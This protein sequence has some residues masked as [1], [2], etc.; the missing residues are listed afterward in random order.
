VGL[1]AQSWPDLEGD[2]MSGKSA[3]GSLIVRTR[4]ATDGPEAAHEFLTSR[5]SRH[6]VTL[7]DRG[8]NLRF[9][10]AGRSAGKIGLAH[11][12]HSAGRTA[13]SDPLDYLIFVA[14]Y[15][16]TVEVL[17]GREQVRGSR[18]GALL[19]PIGTPFTA[20]WDRFG[21]HLL[22]SYQA[23]TG[24]HPATPCAREHGSPGERLHD[25]KGAT[26]G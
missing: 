9:G 12:R 1:P 4:Y 21:I 8:E 23:T 26:Q 19:Y 24:N 15:V 25:R 20:T 11:L 14:I 6:R 5:Y 13:T 7:H 16:G 3:A 17:A 22:N 10:L 2:G 18:G